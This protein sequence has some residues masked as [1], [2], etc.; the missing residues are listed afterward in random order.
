[1][2]NTF[3]RPQNHDY[4]M[5]INLIVVIMS[6]TSVA[7]GRWVVSFFVATCFRLFIFLWRLY[8]VRAA[9][10]SDIRCSY[11]R[12]HTVQQTNLQLHMDVS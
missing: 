1:M 8:S 4:D 11:N 6:Y 10:D 9:I 5:A 7:F 3:F 12:S 2:A